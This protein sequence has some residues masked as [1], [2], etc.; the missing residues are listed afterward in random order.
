[1][2]LYSK[3]DIQQMTLFEG[4]IYKKYD[5]SN[6]ILSEDNK[7]AFVSPTSSNGSATSLSSD[8]SKSKT[9]NPGDK[10]F[11]FN[12]SSYDNDDNNDNITLDISASS[13]SDASAQYNKMLRNPQVKS[14]VK[15]GN[16]TAKVR[17]ESRRISNLRESS[18]DFTKKEFNNLLIK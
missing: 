18:I 13:P 14:L 5:K 1:M 16:V 15:K 11:V 10:E 6:L 4:K 9:N 8:L 3:S 17:M 7:S 12:P 2:K